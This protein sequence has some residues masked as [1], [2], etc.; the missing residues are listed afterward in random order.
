MTI[1]KKAKSKKSVERI[2]RKKDIIKTKKIIQKIFGGNET[3]TCSLS[4]S[5]ITRQS[6][7]NPIIRSINEINCFNKHII[8]N[9]KNLNLSKKLAEGAYG[10]TYLTSINYQNKDYEIIIKINKNNDNHSLNNEKILLENLSLLVDNQLSCN[11]LY[12]YKT[13]NCVN[14]NDFLIEKASGSL[15]GLLN[16][17]TEKIDFRSFATQIIMSIFTFHQYTKCYHMDTHFNNF[18]YNDINQ[19][20]YIEYKI[21]GKVYKTLIS[22][23]I[24]ILWD[25]GLS[26]PINNS[27]LI[28]NN[29]DKYY[30][31]LIYDYERI[32]NILLSVFKNDKINI[33]YIYRMDY[34]NLKL[35]YDIYIILLQ[36][37]DNIKDYLQKNLSLSF[38]KK[39]KYIFE[40]EKALINTLIKKNLIF[41]DI[42]FTN[43]KKYNDNPYEPINENK[44]KMN[45]N[46]YV[47]KNNVQDIFTNKRPFKITNLLSKVEDELKKKSSSSKISSNPHRITSSSRVSSSSPRITSNSSKI[48]ST[49]HRIFSSSSPIK[50]DIS[51]SIPLSFTSNISKK[52]KPQFNSTINYRQQ[53]LQYQ[54]FQQPL[55]YQYFQQPL[56]YYN[57]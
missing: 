14:T 50:S 9:G 52:L 36:Y 44:I 57:K 5:S 10:I 27:S 46:L 22:D 51:S 34:T 38:D 21:F 37:N 33:D 56:Q 7:N 28:Y 32:F 47:K 6:C 40:Q 20:C 19:K 16:K 13:I 42:N 43:I 41:H 48:S 26:E 55:Q 54:Y 29:E 39:I 45:T 18:L 2:N 1:K 12:L 17:N 23:Y 15:E 31:K 3:I 35:L 8:I 53:P 30:L 24:F 49:P 11:F 4:K 25:Y